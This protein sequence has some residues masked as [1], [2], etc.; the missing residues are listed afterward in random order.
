M[1]INLC[2]L[3]LSRPWTY[4]RCQWHHDCT[5]VQLFCQRLRTVKRTNFSPDNF[6]SRKQIIFCWHPRLYTISGITAYLTLPVYCY[7]TGKFMDIQM[8]SKATAKYE[9][10]KTLKADGWNFGSTN[11]NWHF[12]W[13]FKFLADTKIIY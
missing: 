12:W 6:I 2:W 3:L 9:I 4:C 13:Y 5:T 11:I 7:L 10:N 1:V 8:F